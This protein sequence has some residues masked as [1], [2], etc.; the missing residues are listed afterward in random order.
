MG[1]MTHTRSP[2][3]APYHRVHTRTTAPVRTRYPYVTRTHTHTCVRTL[4]GPDATH[5]RTRTALHT[6]TWPKV[7]DLGMGMGPDDIRTRPDLIMEVIA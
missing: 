2:R 5:T 4:S 6:R 7:N 1:H 3:L